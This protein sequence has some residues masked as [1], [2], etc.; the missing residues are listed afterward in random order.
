MTPK[1]LWERIREGVI[2]IVMTPYTADDRMDEAGLRRQIQWMIEQDTTGELCGILLTGTNAEFYALTDQ[3]YMDNIRIVMDEVGGRLPVI[4]GAM[5]IGTKNTIELAKRIQDLGVDGIQIVNPSYIYPSQAGVIKHLVAVG[6]AL[7]V[8]LELYNN[9]ITTHTYLNADTVLE[10]IEHLGDKVVCIKESSPTN[11][12]YYRMIRLVGDK[13]HVVDNNGPFWA[14]QMW[15]AILGCRCFMFRPDWAPIA[16]EFSRAAK[17]MN[18]PAMLDIS[19][20]F[21]PLE[22]FVAQKTK[23]EAGWM[24]IQLSKAGLEHMG[25]PAGQARPPLSPVSPA[26]HA[27]LGRVMEAIGLKK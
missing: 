24:Y 4:A 8:G 10:L 19:A 13:I 22:E 1:Q 23:E 26:T 7:E 14:H 2:P 18:I 12:D 17:T 27:E 20:R 6:N 15:S 21:F 3:E 25:L 9:P 16:Y 11:Y 5:G